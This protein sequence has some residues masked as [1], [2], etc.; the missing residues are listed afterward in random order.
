MESLVE[1]ATFHPEAGQQGPGLRGL[2]ACRDIAPGEA[3]I[4]VPLQ[5]LVSYGYIMAS[6]LVSPG[7]P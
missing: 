2:R 7:V 6:D 3:V 4:S 1:P 5:L